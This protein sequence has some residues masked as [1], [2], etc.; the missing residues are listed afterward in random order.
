MVELFEKSFASFKKL[1]HANDH[2]ITHQ[3]CYVGNVPMNTLTR[4]IA[5]KHYLKYLIVS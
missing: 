2:I 3:L 1:H 5:I 4:V